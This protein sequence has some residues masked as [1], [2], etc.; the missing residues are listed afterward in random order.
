MPGP[1]QLEWIAPFMWLGPCDSGFESSLRNFFFFFVVVVYLFT[2]TLDP[3]LWEFLFI[4]NFI[5]VDFHKCFFFLWLIKS[6][7]VPNDYMTFKVT[8]IVF[9]PEGHSI[10][11]DL[12]SLL[13]KHSVWWLLRSVLQALLYEI[14]LFVVLSVAHWT[15]SLGLFTSFIYF[16]ARVV[17]LPCI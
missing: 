5:P 13:L 3:K 4:P 2:T 11:Y 17:L 9:F 6:C 14:L 10:Q 7:V 15:L 1:S 16:L 8:V 12:W